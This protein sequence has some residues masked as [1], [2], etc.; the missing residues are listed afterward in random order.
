MSLDSTTK[1][2]TLK[3]INPDINL[4]DLME[5]MEELE[6]TDGFFTRLVIYD[7]DIVKWLND[8][9]LVKQNVRGSYSKSKL[10]DDVYVNLRKEY[11]E[12][13]DCK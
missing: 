10:F 4:S 13:L 5:I 2:I 12:I 3:N 1:V 7:S 8:N 11:Y 9:G 6:D